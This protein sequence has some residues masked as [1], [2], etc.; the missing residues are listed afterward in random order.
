M[1]TS[2]HKA[3]TNE[4]FTLSRGTGR[5]ISGYGLFLTQPAQASPAAKTIITNVR[6]L[7]MTEERPIIER[8]HVIIAGQRI[9]VVGE[10]Q[11]DTVDN[12]AVIDGNGATI[13]PGLSDMHVHYWE[14][15]DG[16]LYLANGITNVRNLTGGVGQYRLN[17]HAIDG[18]LMGPRVYTSGP[19]IDGADP[20]RA[21]ISVQVENPQ[22]AIGAVRSQAAGYYP[23][24][25]LYDRLSPD[26]Y[27]AAVAEAKAK[28][29]KIFTHTP[30]AMTVEELLALGVDS[31]EHLDGYSAALVTDGFEATQRFPWAEEWANADP[32]KFAAL[33]RKTAES[34]VWSVP[35][36]ALI[37][38][39]MASRDTEAFLARPEM[40]YLSSSLKD[41]WVSSVEDWLARFHPYLDGQKA[42]KLAFMAALR[43]AG[44]PML[45]GTDP[46][47]PFV[48]PGYAIHD[49]LAA[50]RAAGYT[51]AQILKI[52]TSEAARFLDRES[53]YGRVSAGAAADLI[54]VDG[55][56]RESLDVLKRPLGVMVAGHW[57]DRA[58][59][60]AALEAKAQAVKSAENSP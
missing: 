44:A 57:Y 13:M 35:T 19:L 55:D 23:A 1:P 45:I 24:I 41:G 12:M 39:Q 21:S 33:A 18:E 32:A 53:W 27:R 54:L 5:I 22:Q 34:G 56:P 46:P 42:S 49:E 52:A 60:D 4:E 10:G 47:N 50:F 29:M 59:L 7:T 28:R 36:I 9:D 15:S 48:I 8:G 31:I 38:W 26:S 20:V 51:N 43:E 16:I 30:A 11:P 2:Q 17:Q 14:D 3:F 58:A 25:K 40:R 37:D 6:I